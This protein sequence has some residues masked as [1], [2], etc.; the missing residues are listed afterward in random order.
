[1]KIQLLIENKS[2]KIFSPAI[3]EGVTLISKINAPAKLL[4]SAFADNLLDI[5]EGNHVLFHVDGKKLFYG[6]IFSRRFDGDGFCSVVAYD[7]LRYF[8]NKNNY[9]YENKRASDV[10][11]ML[12]GDLAINTGDIAETQ[13]VIPRRTEISKTL[14]DIINTALAL[15]R[16]HKGEEYQLFADYDKI[17][18]KKTDDMALNI[19]ISEDNARALDYSLSI[20][21]NTFNN[22]KTFYL[23]RKT[24]SFQTYFAK[25]D[26]TDEEWGKLL[27]L[28]E[29]QEDENGLATAESLLRLYNSPTEELKVKGCF[30]HTGVRAGSRVIVSLNT[31]N[32]I[33]NGYM[34][35][36]YCEHAFLNNEHTMNLELKKVNEK[37]DNGTV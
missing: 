21:E 31:G 10:L 37:V 8:K 2:G 9:I 35:V 34:R 12:C 25:D 14:W 33:M 5:S 36:N 28:H 22:V 16:E 18:L 29:L 6:R 11:K 15:E 30:G 4:F 19:L 7:L 24:G 27:Y 23:D 3:K 17:C 13:Y 1:M 32:K 20:D 26:Q